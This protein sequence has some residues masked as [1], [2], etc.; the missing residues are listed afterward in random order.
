M[1]DEQSIV[2][3]LRPSSQYD[4]GVVNVMSVMSIAGKKNSIFNTLDIQKFDTAP[5][6]HH[7]K[8]S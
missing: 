1:E 7:T 2:S 8:H 3:G 4:T 5:I 6:Q